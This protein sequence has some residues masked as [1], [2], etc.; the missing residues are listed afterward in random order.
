MR[1]LPV[2]HDVDQLTITEREIP[3]NSSKPASPALRLI[4]ATATAGA[5][6]GL[7]AGLMYG[8]ALAFPYR[9]DAT[10][11]TSIETMLA[12]AVLAT[13]V[14]VPAVLVY[15]LSRRRRGHRH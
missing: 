2:A 10:W 14:A 13:A 15:A 1:Q 6:F 4:V 8:L 7:L 9:A 12:I 3:S 5:T 11:S